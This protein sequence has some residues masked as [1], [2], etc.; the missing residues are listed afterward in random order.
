[1]DSLTTL[2]TPHYIS[3]LSIFGH[4]A[5]ISMKGNIHLQTL[6]RNIK[7]MRLQAG[8][9]QEEVSELMG[10]STVSTISKLENGN[11][12]RQPSIGKLMELSEI[13]NCE[14]SELLKEE[15]N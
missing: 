9:K 8:L 10:H 11:M 14:I 12:G 2:A 13:F 3:I 7:R 4:Y 15:M 6:G 1:M 5:G